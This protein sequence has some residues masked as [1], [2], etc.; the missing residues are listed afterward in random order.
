MSNDISIIKNNSP[1]NYLEVYEQFLQVRIGEQL[2]GIP[3]VRVR[4]VL[5]PQ[6][7]TKIP[8]AGPE[9]IGLMN[10]RGRIVAVI[11]MRKRLKIESK[12]ESFKKMFVVVES[13]NEF[14]GL[15]IDEVG[16]TKT[17]PISSFESNPENM[18]SSWKSISRGLFKLDNELML[19]LDVGNIVKI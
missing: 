1:E 15:Q 9:I 11:D 5:K 12:Q 10:L 4:D 14:Y 8:L 19:V 17:M 6:K 18:I 3:V 13:E 7:I 2:F 16:D